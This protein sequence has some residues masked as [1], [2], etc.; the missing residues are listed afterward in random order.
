MGSSGNVFIYLRGTAAIGS[1]K[2][3][4]AVEQEIEELVRLRDLKKEELQK[5]IVDYQTLVDKIN[6]NINKIPKSEADIEKML[7]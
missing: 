3:M 1:N 6:L 5:E 4:L 2:G 7:G